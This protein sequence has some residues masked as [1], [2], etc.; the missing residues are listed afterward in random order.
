MREFRCT[1]I[2]DNYS[3]KEIEFTVK[4]IHTNKSQDAAVITGK[5]Y[6][7]VK[8][9]LIVITENRRQRTLHHYFHEA[10]TLREKSEKRYC[11]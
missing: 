11:K 6:P 5:C 7:R 8:E 10:S 3:F 1:S 2:F 4:N 9:S